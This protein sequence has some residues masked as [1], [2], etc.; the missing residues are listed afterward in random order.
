VNIPLKSVNDIDEDNLHS[1]DRMIIRYSQPKDSMQ[2]LN[3]TE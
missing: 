1:E 3:L 2:R